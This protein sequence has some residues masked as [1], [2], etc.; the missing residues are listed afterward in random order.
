MEILAARCEWH[1]LALLMEIAR[2]PRNTSG[3]FV[4]NLSVAIWLLAPPFSRSE[5]ILDRRGSGH[6]RE[7]SPRELNEIDFQEDQRRTSFPVSPSQMPMS[8]LT[9]NEHGCSLCR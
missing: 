1:G 2:L 9:E 7:K 6:E 4:W 5:L 8:K 3:R